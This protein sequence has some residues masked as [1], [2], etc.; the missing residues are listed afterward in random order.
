MALFAGRYGR[1]IWPSPYWDTRRK[2]SSGTS[3]TLLLI[4]NARREASM[5]H[6]KVRL[7]DQDDVDDAVSVYERSN[8]A[9][10]DSD[11][12]SRL[13][14]VAQVTASLHDA[15]RHNAASWFLIGRDDGEAIAM[16]LVHPFRT[17]SGS[18]LV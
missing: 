12:P 15:A 14:R 4:D 9:R 10:R 18:G 8:L 6:I 13:G 5:T 11:W 17:D 3:S 2:R 7:G 16:A 1:T